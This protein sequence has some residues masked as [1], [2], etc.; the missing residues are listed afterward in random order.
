MYE[1]VQCHRKFCAQEMRCSVPSTFYSVS[2]FMISCWP[3]Q[4]RTCL[5]RFASL[6]V[7]FLFVF[8]CKADHLWLC[9]AKSVSESL[10]CHALRHL[11]DICHAWGIGAYWHSAFSVSPSLS[12][13]ISKCSAAYSVGSFIFF[14]KYK[15]TSFVVTWRCKSIE[16]LLSLSSFMR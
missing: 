6:K 16:T 10:L 4:T 9:S 3:P 2:P 13:S 1:R 14:F 7:L 12:F 5:H 11:Q 15:Y 8:A